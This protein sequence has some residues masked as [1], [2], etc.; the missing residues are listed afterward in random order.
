VKE[1]LLRFAALLTDVATAPNVTFLNAQGT[2]VPQS[3]SWHNELH[4]KG[5]G[6]DAF[7]AKFHAKLKALFPTRVA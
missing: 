1:M 4:P 6:F 2:L 3:S 5:A 7:A